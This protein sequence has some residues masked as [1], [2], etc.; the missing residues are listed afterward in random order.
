MRILI[1]SLVLWWGSVFGLYA[2]KAPFYSLEG[3][4][5][6]GKVMKVVQYNCSTGKCATGKAPLHAVS[7]F[8]AQGN[9]TKT[10]YYS[11]GK[12]Y[13][14]HTYSYNDQHLLVR[15][16][17]ED[18]SD[19]TVSLREFTYNADG[20]ITSEKFTGSTSHITSY[21]AYNKAAAPTEEIDFDSQGDTT[22]HVVYSYGSF[23]LET[24][25]VYRTIDE[26]LQLA[27]ELKYRYDEN[28][29]NTKIE[30]LSG[31]GEI[32]EWLEMQYHAN[33]ELALDKEYRG[34]GQVSR[35]R[36][37]DQRGN[38]TELISYQ[39]SGSLFLHRRYV[40]NEAG[41]LT[42][43]T[44]LNSSGQVT[45]RNTCAYD[46]Q[47]NKVEEKHFKEDGTLEYH[48]TFTYDA[49]GNKTRWDRYDEN[50]KIFSSFVY[51]YDVQGNKI[52]EVHIEGN[53]YI[54][55]QYSFTYF[56]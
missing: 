7:D 6:T 22:D 34:N 11:Q 8:N 51:F 32:N 42:E 5:L 45:K 41:Y 53:E 14:T 46:E 50:G 23:G 30:E 37:Y 21:I 56:E 28:G 43:E 39:P 24:K 52:K 20:I 48:A 49:Q 17:S 36:N 9:L 40:Y 31:S 15:H 54:Y 2:Q 16:R 38:V 35:I 3:Q 25:K 18:H 1:S 27:Y 19:K 47:G 55:E 33:G 12:L 29:R 4:G 26:K 10:V 44:D 13:Q